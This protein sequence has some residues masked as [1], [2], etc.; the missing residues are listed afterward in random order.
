MKEE[1]E[2]EKFEAHA[3]AWDGECCSLCG[4][5]RG[6]ERCVVIEEFRTRFPRRR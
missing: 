6:L 5:L 2:E 4:A 3:T 1:E